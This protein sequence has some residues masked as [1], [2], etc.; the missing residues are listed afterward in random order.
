MDI[1]PEARQRLARYME[2][3]ALDLGLTW[4]EVAARAGISIET[5]RLLRTGADGAR[6]LTMRAVDAALEWRPGSVQR[7]LG[8]GEPRDLFTPG[9]RAA[10]DIYPRSVARGIA[11]RESGHEQNGTTG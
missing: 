11:E 4:R 9:E 6:P 10:L 8:G 5:L 2:D 3:R 7:I 1:T